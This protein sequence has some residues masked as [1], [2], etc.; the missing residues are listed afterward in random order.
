MPAAEQNVFSA[1]TY[2][3]VWLGALSI[4]WA[5]YQQTPYNLTELGRGIRNTADGDVV[6]ELE[7]TKSNWPQIRNQFEQGNSINI[8]G[9]SGNLDFDIVTEELKT[10]IDVWTFSAGLT[11]FNVEMTCYANDC[12]DE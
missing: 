4:A 12:L 11:S 6:E 9:V 7:L 2:D 1:H 3:A 10:G 8:T 5:H